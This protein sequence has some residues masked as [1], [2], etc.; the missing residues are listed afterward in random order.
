MRSARAD[1]LRHVILSRISRMRGKLIL[2]SL[3]IV[4]LMVGE[5]LEPWP[6]KVIF[7]YVLLGR[8]LPHALGFLAPLLGQGKWV[9]VLWISLA[10][11]GIALMQAGASYVQIFCTSRIG[12][13]VAYGLRRE[14]FT[15]LQRLSLSFYNRE[16]SGELLTKLTADT[17]AMSELF[18]DAMVEIST[19][20]LILAGMLTLMLVINWQLGLIVLATLVPLFFA[21]YYLF[22]RVKISVRTQRAQEGRIASRISENL[23]SVALVQAFGREQYEAELFDVESARTRDESVRAARM[24]AAAART[25]EIISAV[26]KWA[27]VLFGSLQVL[28]GHMTPGDVLIFW[29]YVGKMYK[30]IRTLSRLS[31]KFTRASV[32]AERIGEVL[33]IDPEVQDAPDAIQARNLRGRIVF[34]HVTFDYGDGRHVLKDACFTVR[35]GQRV[36][37]VGASGAGKST[38]VCLLLRLFDPQQGSVLVDGLDIRRYARESLRREIGVVLQDAVL[39]GATVRENIAYGKRDADTQEVIAAAEAANAHDF[40]S[41]LE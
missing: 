3:S 14:L 13:E 31:T 32:S 9:A 20:P 38:I 37:L 19:H 4:A 10:I 27:V 40:I 6:F 16:R 17:T 41:D 29:G 21:L 1:R 25:V 11:V 39:M 24:E 7:D 28:R 15:H 2:A 36:A 8:S 23:G 18:R 12:Y 35:P 33:E 30:P 34:D 26:G 22:R 5:I